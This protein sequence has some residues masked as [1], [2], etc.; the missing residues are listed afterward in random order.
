M[1]LA[2]D[3][4]GRVK[5]MFNERGQKV[6]EAGPATP[7][8]LLGFEGAPNAGDKFNVMEDE[9]EARNIAL[10]RQQLQREQSLP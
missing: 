1:M 9:R 5:A 7:V 4:Y 6:T 3:N 2:G 8:S 10:K